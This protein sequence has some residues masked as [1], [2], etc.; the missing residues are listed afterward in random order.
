MRCG[1]ELDW[2]NLAVFYGG[3]RRCGENPVISTSYSNS[4][5]TIRVDMIRKVAIIAV[6]GKIG[7]PFLSRIPHPWNGS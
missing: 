1:N 5:R 3:L 4:G 2:K 7:K 6:G